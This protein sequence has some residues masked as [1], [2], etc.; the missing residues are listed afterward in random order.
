MQHILHTTCSRSPHNAS[1]VVSSPY[2][3]HGIYEYITT[4]TIILWSSIHISNKGL[5]TESL[6]IH[7]FRDSTS[8]PYKNHEIYEYIMSKVLARPFPKGT[9]PFGDSNVPFGSTSKPTYFSSHLNYL[10]LRTVWALTTE[11]CEH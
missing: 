8:S 4:I 3:N 1:F 2:K 9:V 11:L 5:C 7:I 6:Y 10:N